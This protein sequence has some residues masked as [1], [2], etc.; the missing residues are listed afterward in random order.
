[1]GLQT[2][3]QI[4]ER[5]AN[6]KSNRSTFE[7]EWQACGDH[8]FGRR[9][10]IEFNITPGRRRTKEILDTT[11]RQSLTQ[12]AG[13]L[14]G[15]L[16]DPS[17]PW[18][19][20]MPV[21]DD[22]AEQQPIIEWFEQVTRRMRR[23]FALPKAGF[24]VNMAEIFYDIGG[25]GTSAMFTVDMGDYTYFSARPLG[26]IYISEDHLGV[27]DLVFRRFR[28]TA[29]QAAQAWPH[30]ATDNKKIRDSLEKN[31]EDTSF[32]IHL[33]HHVDDP[34]AMQGRNRE[35]RKPW[36]SVYVMED[37]NDIVDEG[38][39]YEMP[40]H[41]ARWSKE[42]GESYGRGPGMIALSDGKMANEM[43]RTTLQMGQKAADPPLTVPDDGVLTQVITTPGGLNVVREDLLVRT[44]G[45]PI[46]TLPTGSNFPI[47]Q[48]LL[49]A[50]RQS[51]RETFY[52]NLMQLFRDP[53]MTA[54]QVLELSAEAQRMMA[55][56]LSRLKV[57][58]LD[59][60]VQRQFYLMMRRQEFPPMPQ[61][62]AGREFEVSYNSPVLRSQRLPEARAAME[63]WQAAFML[64]QGGAPQVLD[65]LDP[66]ATIRLIHEA[67]GAPISVLRDTESRDG[68]R[69]ARAAEQKKA[70]ELEQIGQIAE[71]AGKVGVE[72]P[73]LGAGTA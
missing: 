67:R 10:F 5:F 4:L 26:E 45:N 70:Q 31:P 25:F 72:V 68:I 19:S 18:F 40:I 69:D 60:M 35:T 6:V 71:A 8:L 61:Q 14:Q 46:G 62:L 54:T 65:N 3:K 49:E 1:M 23:A 53:R 28:F 41:V 13:G 55:P 32:Y 29:R 66:D 37:S 73:E 56:M 30:L 12:L 51:I 24:G 39:F 9:D 22:L 57:E 15:L 17:T 48:E 27:I 21:D 16:A 59:P 7:T 38:G 11:A 42:A 52:S 47:T 34:S 33:L 64:A 2:A 20:V 36:R 43:M 44:R 63:T 50:T 58:L